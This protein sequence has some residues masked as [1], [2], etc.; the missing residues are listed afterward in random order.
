MDVVRRNIEA[1]RGRVT[2][3]SVEGAGSAIEIRLPLTLAIIDGFLMAV[4]DSKF[5]L[6]LETVVEVIEGA[7]PTAT[8]ADGRGCI[9]LRG[10]L[11]PVIDLRQLYDLGGTPARSSIVVA[12]AGSEHFGIRVD[13]LLGQHQ[14]VIKPLGRIFRRLRGLSGSTILGNG[15]VALIL[16]VNSFHDSVSRSL[17]QAANPQPITD[18]T[19]TEPS[20]V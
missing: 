20:V 7:R 18:P 10:R 5:I 14:T 6:P 19:R 8:G 9:E 4:G 13:Q 2:V 16:D 12:R 1:L 17:T 3:G 15:E 11:L